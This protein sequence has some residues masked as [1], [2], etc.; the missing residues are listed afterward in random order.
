VLLQQLTAAPTDLWAYLAQTAPAGALINGL[1]LGALAILFATDRVLTK[2]QHL[3]RIADLVT[4]HTAALEAQRV[5]HLAILAEK[6]RAMT[7]VTESRDGYK[8]ATEIE[9]ERANTATEALSEFADLGRLATQLLAS[10][11][12]VQKGPDS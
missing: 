6:D 7:I 5:Y 11:D 10:L 9:R 1:G 3:R 8:E 2:G 4:A 12:S